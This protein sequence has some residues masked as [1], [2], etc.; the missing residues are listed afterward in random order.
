MEEQ[1]K[2]IVSAIAEGFETLNETI[3]GAVSQARSLQTVYR[4][5]DEV[6]NRIGITSKELR[7]NLRSQKWHVRDLALTEAELSSVEKDESKS[8]TKLGNVFSLL[9]SISPTLASK[10]EEISDATEASGFSF[11]S[12]G[13]SSSKAGG[14]LSVAGIVI[15]G[16]AKVAVTLFKAFY[17][18]YKSVV[19]FKPQWLSI[20]FISMQLNRAL[21]SL[22]APLLEVSGIF[23][24]WKATLIDILL[25]VLMPIID[26]LIDLFLW[27]M[28]LPEPIKKVIGNIILF[29][30]VITGALSALSQIIILLSSLGI[31]MGSLTVLLAPF[32]A[33][34]A[35]ATAAVFGLGDSAEE[36]TDKLV[37]FINKGVDKA[38]EFINNFVNKFI[39][40]LPLIEDIAKKISKAL[41]DGLA[42]IITS[43][44][45]NNFVIAFIDTLHATYE[46]NKDSLIK[47]A[48]TIIKWL[49][50]FFLTFLP[51]IV[52]LAIKILEAFLR[53]FTDPANKAKIVP[54]VEKIINFIQEA[55]TN[56][57]PL[58][59]QVGWAIIK[60]IFQGMINY[61][62]ENI[63]AIAHFIASV[64]IGALVS[65][66]TGNPALGAVSA[67]AVN[68]LLKKL[69]SP[70]TKEIP[71]P[72]RQT[73][74]YIPE[75]A[76]YLLHR[77]EYVV[78]AGEKP[79][80][81]YAYAPNITVYATVS[82]DV[83]IRRLASELNKY[84][85]AD[86]KRMTE[87]RTA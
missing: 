58:I 26:T 18:L 9:G 86:F 47:I 54:A 41:I 3:K 74:G 10:F 40:N 53:A 82:S 78:P 43:A 59:L 77:G 48:E 13:A 21:K 57:T 15:G 45:L 16:V 80:A 29:G 42:K 44:E 70:K 17:K 87:S 11:S 2:I 64:L 83:D 60:G 37:S 71:L 35:G 34:L 79:A 31:S 12:L 55:V 28:D 61:L 33:I 46:A 65:V 39:E 66:F 25:P 19:G 75:T 8:G 51:E 6:A 23:E 32:V 36:T 14:A 68:E 85:V 56:L 62:V 50:Y 1:I 5:V 76:P 72:S 7:A 4:G 63:T 20:M 27:F 81:N 84:W 22:I 52:D 30:I 67:V 69:P 49:V 38:V 73:G 24:V